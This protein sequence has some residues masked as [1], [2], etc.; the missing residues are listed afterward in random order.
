MQMAHPVIFATATHLYYL[1]EDELD[2]P[3]LARFEII[4]EPNAGVD[5]AEGRPIGDSITV[6]FTKDEEPYPVRR[7]TRAGGETAARLRAAREWLVQGPT[8]EERAEGV[9][10]WISAESADG[11]RTVELDSTGS[12]AIDFVDLS[13]LRPSGSTCIRGQITPQEL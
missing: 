1:V 5:A 3:R 8:A 10:S 4:K 13:R 12:G 6:L 11:I 7:P 2:I 9:W